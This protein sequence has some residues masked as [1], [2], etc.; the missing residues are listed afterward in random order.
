MKRISSFSIAALI[1][2]S[3]IS[4]SQDS[5]NSG[6]SAGIPEI[7]PPVSKA[8]PSG[9]SSVSTLLSRPSDQL[10]TYA[11]NY[12][13]LQ[14][15]FYGASQTKIDNLLKVV[16]DRMAEINTRSAESERTCL[17]ATPAEYS[18]TVLGEA[19][20]VYFQCYDIMGDGS[21]GILFGKKDNV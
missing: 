12:S 7:Q 10:G 19:K 11:L 21:G 4:C 1:T 20:T 5:K 2:I 8:T 13:E 17:S 6:S 14:Q 9:L 3:I 15:R 18:L 16:D